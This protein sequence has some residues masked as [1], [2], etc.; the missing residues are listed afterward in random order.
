MQAA[1][2]LPLPLLYLSLPS[3]FTLLFEETRETR[4]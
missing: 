3:T 2:P 4:R 1:S